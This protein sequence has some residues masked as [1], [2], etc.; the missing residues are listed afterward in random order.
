MNPLFGIQ[1]QGLLWN[2]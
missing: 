1:L 2:W